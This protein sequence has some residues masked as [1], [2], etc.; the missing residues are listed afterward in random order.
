MQE[1]VVLGV[2]FLQGF[3]KHMGDNPSLEDVMKFHAGFA[4]GQAEKVASGACDGCM[5]RPAAEWRETCLE[6]DRDIAQRYGLHLVELNEEIWLV[7]D[8]GASWLEDLLNFPLN[9]PMWHTIRASICGIVDI[10]INYHE[11]KGYRERC[12]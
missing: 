2:T 3:R 4:I 1:K 8:E 6:I 10:D 11:R 9:S 12:D 5:F 7:N